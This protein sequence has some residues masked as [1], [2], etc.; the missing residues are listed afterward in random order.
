MRGALLRRHAAGLPKM[1]T[2]Q[3]RPHR[4]DILWH[5]PSDDMRRPQAGSTAVKNTAD[6]LPPRDKQRATIAGDMMSLQPGSGGGGLSA[7]TAA[8]FIRARYEAAY[9]CGE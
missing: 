3:S 7:T 2:V 4:Q 5:A 8:R 6:A 1:P 9:F